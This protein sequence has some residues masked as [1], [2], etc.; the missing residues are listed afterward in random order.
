MTSNCDYIQSPAAGKRRFTWLSRHP[1]GQASPCATAAADADARPPPAPAPDAS[2]IERH[3]QQ[4]ARRHSRA[5]RY[6]RCNASRLTRARSLMP[7]AHHSNPRNCHC[8]RLATRHM[9]F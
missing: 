1:R 2:K 8:R 3:P 5:R 4:T 6:I 7:C 9:C